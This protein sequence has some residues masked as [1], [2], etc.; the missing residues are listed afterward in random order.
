MDRPEIVWM[1]DT[2]GWAYDKIAAEL[3]GRLP[4]FRHTKLHIN[5]VDRKDK[6]YK[7]VI[8]RAD[9]IVC[10]FPP[11]MKLLDDLSNVMIRLDGFRAFDD[12]HSK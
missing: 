9:L 1:C 2:K 11:W 5:E 12:E 3:S 8:K 10:L 6:H 7:L 4:S